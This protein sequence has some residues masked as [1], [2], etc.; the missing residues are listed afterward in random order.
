MFDHFKDLALEGLRV[1]IKISTNFATK[2]T[3]DVDVVFTTKSVTSFKLLL[4]IQKQSLPIITFFQ[5]FSL[6]FFDYHWIVI[7]NILTKVADAVFLYSEILRF[8][9]STVILHIHNT[10]TTLTFS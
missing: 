4:H 5:Q 2:D 9:I 8:P 3:L 6:F 10:T 1:S 7:K